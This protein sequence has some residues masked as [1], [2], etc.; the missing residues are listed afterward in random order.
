MIIFEGTMDALI[1][2][3][4]L[5]YISKMSFSILLTKNNT[6][7]DPDVQKDVLAFIME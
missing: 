7:G 2:E 4:Q 6:E 3:E 1:F 5:D